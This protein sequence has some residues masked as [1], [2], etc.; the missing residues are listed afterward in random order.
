MMRWLTLSLVTCGVVASAGAACSSDEPQATSSGATPTGTVMSGEVC[1][2]N[3]NDAVRLALA[4][5]CEDCHKGTSG[6]AFFSSLAAFEDLLVYDTKYVQAGK[7]NEGKLIELLEGR[8][9]EPYPKMPTDE[10]F[11]EKAAA[12]KTKISLPQIKDWIQNLPPQGASRKGPNVA[13]ATTRR[14]RADEFLLSVQRTL[15]L[16]ESAGNLPLIPGT[17]Q[18]FAP[19]SPE[20][21]SGYAVSLSIYQ[22][23]GGASYLQGTAP[24][25]DWSTGAMTAVTQIASSS[26]F[27]AVSSSSK[28]IFVHAK[29]TMKLATDE[30]LI[31]KNAKQLVHD[32]LLIPDDDAY[33]TRLVDT[34]Y[35]PLEAKGTTAAWAGVCTALL[36]D[37]RFLT[38]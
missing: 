29:P 23:L 35:K 28:K 24:Q 3:A 34:V 4:P 16:P 9:G 13:A 19:D 18:P 31:R 7:P 38:F 37:P 27:Q 2:Q 5:V 6:K 12:G 36:R 22:L 11:V 15:G 8:A 10:S 26:C 14:L 1:A 20:V 21:F 32:F 25:A 30:A 33:V 17:I